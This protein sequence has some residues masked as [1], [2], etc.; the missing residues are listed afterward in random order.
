MDVV[1]F[2]IEE[3]ASVNVANH[4]CITALLAACSMRATSASDDRAA[5]TVKVRS[6][7]SVCVRKCLFFSQMLVSARYTRVTTRFACLRFVLLGG[8]GG[9]VCVLTLGFVPQVLLEAG[10][11]WTVDLLGRSP[12]HVAVAAP[13]TATVQ[14]LLR[15]PDA[16]RV[17]PL[18]SHAGLTAAAMVHA[19][20]S[21][22]PGPLKALLEPPAAG[23][24]NPPSTGLQA[25]S[26][27]QPPHGH[28]GGRP[29]VGGGGHTSGRT[30]GRT[31]GHTSGRVVVGDEAGVEEAKASPTCARAVIEV[32]GDATDISDIVLE[33]R[34]PP[35]VGGPQP[36]DP[37]STA[38]HDSPREPGPAAV[39]GGAA[40][41]VAV[42]PAPPSPP[43]PPSPPPDAWA[44]SD[45][46]YEYVSPARQPVPPLTLPRHMRVDPILAHKYMMADRTLRRRG[47]GAAAAGTEVGRGRAPSASLPP[48]LPPWD[49]VSLSATLQNVVHAVQDRLRAVRAVTEE[50]RAGAAGGA[51][52][53]GA[54]AGGGGTGGD[55]APRHQDHLVA[56]VSAAR[57]VHRRIGAAATRA[58]IASRIAQ[59]AATNKQSRSKFTKFAPRLMP[60]ASSVEVSATRLTFE[61]EAL[62]SSLAEVLG[63]NVYAAETMLIA[64]NW[65][66]DTVV[67][68]VLC[69]ERRLLVEES[70]PRATC[71]HAFDRWLSQPE[72]EVECEVCFEDVPLATTFA[73][74]C[75]HQFCRGCW[76]EALAAVAGS[77]K[78]VRAVLVLF[79]CVVMQ[80]A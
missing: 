67:A 62:C 29:T 39:V 1:R 52:A 65:S 47:G 16:E 18:R 76:R 30:S 40:A 59:R 35:E 55:A 53:G 69:G 78:E 27:M 70:F 56:A 2:L 71:R 80:R 43:S 51:A 19:P 9:V 36:N 58:N 28:Y 77:R 60:E 13:N 45:E 12:L 7:A 32:R 54:A 8:G 20:S 5:A 42:P 34:A 17:L 72:D 21:Q 14:E 50:H 73:L 6:V 48:A 57:D 75:G 22:A 46:E 68:E 74:A 3:G 49:H 38:T 4:H 24:A 11:T 31:S 37:T 61:M 10:A 66:A 33:P 64:C 25:L 44:S 23:T 79:Y 63:V 26:C 41:S 15:W